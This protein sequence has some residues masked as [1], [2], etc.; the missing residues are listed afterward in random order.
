MKFM[1]PVRRRALRGPPKPNTLSFHARPPYGS[2]TTNPSSLEEANV[3]AL[4]SARS[5]RTTGCASS[6]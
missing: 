4:P 5:T 3:R 2:A 6:G 1:H